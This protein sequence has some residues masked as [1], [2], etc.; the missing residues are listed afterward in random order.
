METNPRDYQRVVLRHD[1][2]R[3]RLVALGDRRASRPGRIIVAI[4]GASGAIY[5]LRLIKA[6]LK[7]RYKKLLP[8]YKAGRVG[9]AHTGQLAPRDI[10]KLGL[11]K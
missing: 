2:L 11:R 7:A 3:R 1:S 4:T 10:K 9:E 6:A 5:S 8:L